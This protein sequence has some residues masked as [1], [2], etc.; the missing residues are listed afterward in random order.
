MNVLVKGAKGD[1]VDIYL[2]NEFNMGFY[3]L[4]CL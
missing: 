2:Y 4:L 1:D 3:D